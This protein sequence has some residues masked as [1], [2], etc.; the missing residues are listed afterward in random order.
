MEY[1]FFDFLKLVGSLALFLYGMK[2]MSEGLQKMAGEQLRNILAAMTRNRVM[3]VL[4]GVLVTALIQSS[5]AAS[6]MVVSFV[7]AGLLSLAQSIGVIMG[8]NIGTTVT[9]WMIALFGF[10]KFS[11]SII[12]IPLLGIGLPLIFSAKSK[13]KSLGEFIFGFAFLFLGL[14][15]LKDSMPDLQNNPEVLAFVSDFASMGFL[16]TLIFLAIGTILTVIV[17][18]SSATVAITLIMCSRG[19]IGFESAA[20]MIMGENIGTTITANLAAISANISAK[21]A[22]FAHLMFNVL[23]VIWMLFVF[24]FFVN[25]VG[26]IVNSVGTVNPAD[27][28]G[29]M[30]S[31]SPKELSLVTTAPVSELSADLVTKQNIYHSYEAATSYGLS[32]FHTMFNVGNVLIMIWFVNLY[33]KICKFIIKSKVEDEDEEFQLQFI[34]TGML[35]TAEL[36]ILQAEKEMEVYARRTRKMFKLVQKLAVTKD[37][38]KFVKLFTRIEKYEGISDR[39]EI[40]IGS[41]LNKVA[42]GRLSNK[43]KEQIRAILRGVTEIESIADSCHNMARHYKRKVESNTLFPDDLRENI[44]TMWREVEKAFDRMQFVLKEQEVTDSDMT[45]TIKHENRINELRN[46]FKQKNL[47]DV[48]N[49]V[50]NY[51]TGVFYMDVVQ[52]CERMGDYIINVVQS[53]K[54]KKF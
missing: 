35:S 44:N 47:E 43:S 21:R 10:G 8:A 39:M 48:N 3:G 34:T 41:Y 16:S 46:M 32:L 54:F 42:E 53:V 7:N 23:G 51:Q 50:Y 12:S 14:D 37:E 27:M 1:T 22:A 9:A 26:G 11:I 52:E 4:T 6:V 30:S 20:A 15:Y 2:I 38:V 31:L 18:S 36:S 13:R 33:E 17:Q 25:M 24:K 28:T 5:S 29:F 19:W 40:E 49:N 45:D